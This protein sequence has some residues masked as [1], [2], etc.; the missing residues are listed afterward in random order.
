MSEHKDLSEVREGRKDKQSKGNG[1]KRSRSSDSSS[2]KPKAPSAL[3]E[4]AKKYLRGEAANITSQPTNKKHKGLR[5]T[6][7]ETRAQITDSA[8]RTAATEVLLPG[9]AG[10][11]ELEP[12]QKTYKLKQSEIKLNVDLNTAKNAFDLQLTSFGPYSA[13]YSRNGR[14]MVIAGQRGHVATYDCLRSC[15]GAELHLRE[16]VH[17]VHYLH[18]ETLFA[19]AQNKYT[20]IY[21]SKGVEIHCMKQHE[22][23]YRLDFLPYHFLLTTVGHSGWIKWHDVSIGNYVAGYQ[24]G[25]GPIKVLRHNPTNA[26]S[27]VGHSNGVVSLWSPASGKALVSMFCHKGPVSALALDR[28]GRYMTTAGLDGLMKVW[29][30]RKYTCL[31]SY[32]LDRPAV[33]LDISDRGLVAMGVGRTVQVLKDAFTQPSDLTYLKHTIRTPGASTGGG[34]TAQVKALASSIQVNTV[35]FRPL[36]DV[37][38]CGHSNGVSSVI[39]PGAGEPNFDTFENNPFTN[40]KQRR[41]GE[42]QNL[43]QKLSHEMIGLDANFVG[44]VDK[45]QDTLRVEHQEIFYGANQSEQ[46]KKERNKK[47]GRNKIS[48]KLKRKQKNVV[49]AQSLKLR[50]KLQ[51]QRAPVKPSSA[52][53]PRDHGALQR[54]VK[55]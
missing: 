32:Q 11:I 28:E 26:V 27:H 38:C 30:L 50:E 22:R 47:R 16:T 1:L 18:N 23:P 51:E 40:S 37:L 4:S 36:E 15:V 3:D 54:F 7:I 20:Y 14:H 2:K 17:D 49:D 9:D 34:V 19:A 29:D 46:S 24:T 43:L 5:K 44:Q 42:V 33:S 21:D 39:V 12:G 13:S 45:N 25:H 41:E 8:S 6:L 35:R 31:H 55:K 52:E 48:A 53:K 10:F